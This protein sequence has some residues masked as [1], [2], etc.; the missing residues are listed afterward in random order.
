MKQLFKSNKIHL[1]LIAGL[2]WCAGAIM[3]LI[4][5][6]EL[7]NITST[8]QLII[9]SLISSLIIWL[10]YKFILK[11]TAIKNINRIILLK[12]PY[13]LYQFQAIKMYI[14]IIIMIAA[15]TLL[16]KFSLVD[17]EILSTLY[18]GIG[19]AL[20]LSSFEYFKFLFR[21]KNY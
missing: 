20:F 6:K 2:F 15:G 21:S 3:L 12:S 9:V 5:A 19:G 14:A 1:I 17:N 8:K 11:K 4:K 7:I 16:R 10:K 18:I 13:Y